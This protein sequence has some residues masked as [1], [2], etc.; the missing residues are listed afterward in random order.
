MA[1]DITLSK[2]VRSNLLSLQHTAELLNR[3]QERLASG[4]K[5]N[6]ALDNP[7]N[8]FTSQGLTSRANDL[9]RLLDSISNAVQTIE[10]A[11]EGISAITKLIESA[12]ALA[13]SAQQS[14]ETN[15]E[16]VGSVSGLTG[17]D[18]AVFATWDVGDTLTVG[19]GT[20]TGTFTYAAGNDVQDLLDAINNT[21]NLNATASLNA[22]GAIVFEG[23]SSSDLTVGG[24]ADAG[25]L[26]AVGFVAG[27]TDGTLNET[28]E[29]AAAQFDGIL[30]QITQ[31]AGDAS[32]NGVNLLNSDSLEVVF[33][34]DGTS[35][36]TINGVDF[37]ATGL[38][39]SATTLDF[40]EDAEI[41]AAVD[42]LDAAVD[43]L[44]AQA[45]AF[46]SN[47]SIVQTR[48]DFTKSMINVLQIGSDNL[49]LADTNEEG[50][51]MLAL[52]T[53]QQ[54]STVALSLAAQADQNVLQLF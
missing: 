38:G 16:V 54:L 5:V 35:S 52:N 19:D 1:S 21:A 50:A 22:D 48:Q 32:F 37:S 49:V 41:D 24:T 14:A 11:D 43:T 26:A 20:T 29:S 4:K 13:S 18:T 12:Q 28:R 51:N 27:V 2:G 23:T 45:T 9:S 44:K 15:A 6:S 7:I 31:L 33:N 42:A 36:L 39:L 34:E 17:A 25:E 10:A 40:Q 46:G 30:T 8:F 3:T 47:L 53:R